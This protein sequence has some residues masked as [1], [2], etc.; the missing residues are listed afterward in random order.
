MERIAFDV[1]ALHLG[2]ADPDACLVG[3]FVDR[4]FDN[5]AGLGVRCADPLDNGHAAV[6]RSPTPVLRAFEP[7]S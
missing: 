7:R 6:Q 4:T 5:E 3:A 2:L 1:E